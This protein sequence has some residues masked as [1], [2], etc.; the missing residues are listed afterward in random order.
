MIL[1]IEY[2]IILVINGYIYL[3]I[4]LYFFVLFVSGE[5]YN[6]NIFFYLKNW[7]L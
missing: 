5:L 7:C 1:F 2:K 4:N 3:Y 6:M